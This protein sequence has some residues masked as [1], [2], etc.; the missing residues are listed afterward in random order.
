MVFHLILALFTL[1]I[2]GRQIEGEGVGP[3]CTGVLNHWNLE[4]SSIAREFPGPQKSSHLA[5]AQ[6][7]MVVLSYRSRRKSDAWLFSSVPKQ[8]FANPTAL[9]YLVGFQ[10]CPLP[11]LLFQFLVTV[12]V[13]A[14][15]MPGRDRD[16]SIQI[17]M[18]WSFDSVSVSLPFDFPWN[19]ELSFHA[20]KSRLIQGPMAITERPAAFWTCSGF[21]SLRS[22]VD[23][24][25]SEMPVDSASMPCNSVWCNSRPVHFGKLTTGLTW[26]CLLLLSLYSGCELGCSSVLGHM[27]NNG[28]ALSLIPTLYM[29]VCNSNSKRNK[30]DF[31]YK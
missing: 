1:F 12:L 28:K 29:E 22:C 26:P 17:G 5:A 3:Q 30:I 14:E 13:K 2:V 11:L 15:N 25:A 23:P 27:L 20:D 7:S 24:I 10:V 18:R 6:M 16:L 31:D 4:H 8:D 19:H 21:S 9:P